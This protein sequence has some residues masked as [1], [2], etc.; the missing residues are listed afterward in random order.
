[1][2][3]AAGDFEPLEQVAP[4]LPKELVRIVERCLQRDPEQ[5]YA[6]AAELQA[7]LLRIP[8][9][10]TVA[11]PA[12]RLKGSREAVA[13][14][15]EP[16]S[17]VPTELPVCPSIPSLQPNPPSP[18][19]SAEHG[20]NAH[21]LAPPLGADLDS[22]DE[23]DGLDDPRPVH[24]ELD[25]SPHAGRE[26]LVSAPHALAAD[27]TGARARHGVR[28]TGQGATAAE[29]EPDRGQA[30]TFYGAAVAALV[31]SSVLLCALQ[32]P[33]A[34][35]V[36]LG[37]QEALMGQASGSLGGAIAAVGSLV[38]FVISLRGLRRSSIGMLVAGTGLLVSAL[39]VGTRTLDLVKGLTAMHGHALAV[40]LRW[41]I[42]AIPIGLT[43][44][45]MAR[46]RRLWQHGD[47]VARFEALGLVLLASAL[48]MLTCMI[49]LGVG[50]C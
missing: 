39:V 44:A 33:A 43:L 12:L 40:T 35:L 8:T 29:S 15:T 19:S 7:E 47:A 25:F 18:D 9:G 49:S 2:R 36:A 48:A 6:S 28:A 5:R 37:N 4:S 31:V 13:M 24:L 46:A 50:C 42:A 10:N 45:V 3:I 34:V 23:A 30:L 32:A 38:G 1:M 22:I 16:A 26:A 27:G 14:I 11:S 41:S 21:A 20:I 17:S